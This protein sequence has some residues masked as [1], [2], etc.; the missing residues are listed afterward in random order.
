METGSSR[1]SVLFLLWGWA[2]LV[3]CAPPA[4][5]GGFDSPH[6]AADLFASRAAA[7][8]PAMAGRNIPSLI[9]LLESDD[10]AVRMVAIMALEE[11]TGTSLG[12]RHFDPPWMREQYVDRWVRAWED[13]AIV[14]IDGRTVGRSS[15]NTET[16]L[17]DKKVSDGGAS[18]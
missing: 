2:G 12:Y 11:L 17:V 8:D 7:S 9:E 4:E 15:V 3:S 13:D 18:R 10:P 14:L 5:R 6:P 1:L 16:P